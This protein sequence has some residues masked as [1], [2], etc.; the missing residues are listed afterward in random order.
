MKK[1]L[2]TLIALLTL[3]PSLNASQSHASAGGTFTGREML[4]SSVI[5]E[6]SLTLLLVVLYV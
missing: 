2:A 3:F 1:Y 4:T 6:M 5:E